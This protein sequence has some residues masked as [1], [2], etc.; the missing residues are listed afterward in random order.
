VFGELYAGTSNFSVD[1]LRGASTVSDSSVNLEALAYDLAIRT[2]G[3][4]VDMTME[5]GAAKFELPK[6]DMSNVRYDVAVNHVHGPTYAAVAAKFREIGTP[7]DPAAAPDPKSVMEPLMA[8]LEHSPELVIKRIGFSI[9]E[10]EVGITGTVRLKDFAKVDL[11]DPAAQAELISKLDASADVWFDEGVLTR[12]WSNG[13]VQQTQNGAPSGAERLAAIRNQVAQL[14]QQGFL[15]RKDD[16]L[17]TRIEFKQGM[18][19][20]NGKPLSKGP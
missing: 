1:S 10:G 4:Y 20:A 17:Q 6:L 5:L 8:L 18:L 15:A 13:S 3:D 19:T 7:N 14:E 2:D 16:R 9:P 11:Q 12:D